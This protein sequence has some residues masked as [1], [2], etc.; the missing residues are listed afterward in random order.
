MHWVRGHVIGLSITAGVLIGGWL[1]ISIGQKLILSNTKSRREA[2][3][4]RKLLSTIVFVA[5]VIVLVLTWGRLIPAHGTFFG[6]L[7]AGL[8]I[9]LREPLLSIAGRIAIFAGRIYDAGDRIQI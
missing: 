9:A 2:Y 1:V 4:Y 3:R 7:G 8:A 5:G 6:L